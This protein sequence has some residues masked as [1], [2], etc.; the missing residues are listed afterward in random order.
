MAVIVGF[1]DEEAGAESGSSIGSGGRF[2]ELS[3]FSRSPALSEYWLGREE[4]RAGDN[5]TSHLLGL[6][7]GRTSQ[8][9]HC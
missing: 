8:P 2:H 5:G 6:D 1:E 9:R 3:P 4:W 7:S